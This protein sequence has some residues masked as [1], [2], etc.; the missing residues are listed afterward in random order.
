MKPEQRQA[1]EKLIL[2][3][4]NLIAT[5]ENETALKVSAIGLKRNSD[6]GAN[7]EVRTT[8]QS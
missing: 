7:L 1:M 2:A 6:G 4:E 5:F 8:P 3:L